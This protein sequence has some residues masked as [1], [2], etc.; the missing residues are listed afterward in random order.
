MGAI[1]SQ[2]TSLTIVYSIIYDDNDN[3][4]HIGGDDYDSGDDYSNII[5]MVITILLLIIM[6]LISIC[7][8][9]VTGGFCA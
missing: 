6:I 9:L 8:P 1:A 5:I 7:K 4:A 3:N 2:I